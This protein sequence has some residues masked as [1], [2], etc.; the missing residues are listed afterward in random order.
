[1]N[2]SVGKKRFLELDRSNGFEEFELNGLLS[3]ASGMGIERVDRALGGI[4]D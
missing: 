1:M 3:V 2:I 4:K